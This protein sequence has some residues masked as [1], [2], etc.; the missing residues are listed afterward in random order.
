MVGEDGDAA[1]VGGEEVMEGV[2]GVRE[3]AGEA[4]GEERG[5]VVYELGVGEG[6]EVGCCACVVG[7]GGL[8]GMGLSKGGG[9][10]GFEAYHPP[11]SSQ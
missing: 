6:G 2:F 8:G 9:V 7:L 5:V 11:T 10:W 4:D 3:G 1:A